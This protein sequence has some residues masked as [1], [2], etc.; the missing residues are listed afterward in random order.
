MSKK[1]TR[2]SIIGALLCAF[3][4]ISFNSQA[5]SYRNQGTLLYYFSKYV[6]W[7]S[8]SGDSFV[9]SVY[10]DANVANA[11]SRIMKDRKIDNKPI[12]VRRCGSLSQISKSS[13]LVYIPTNKTSMFYKIKKY[14]QSS[15]AMIVTEK[16]GYGRKGS[17][18]N[19]VYRDRRMKFELN[20]A[21]FTRSNLKVSR[22][23][24]NRAISI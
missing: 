13:N 14:M 16:S 3:L 21:A 8:S 20:R 22:L 15:N 5:Q 11:I 1:I 17:H 10:G 2:L 19:L 4:T 18:I 7:P 23:L 12:I 9:I 24:T 6:Q